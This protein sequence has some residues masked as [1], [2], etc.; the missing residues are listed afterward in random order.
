[1]TVADALLTRRAVKHYDP[2]FELPAEDVRALL[3][4]IALSPTAFNMQNRHVVVVRDPAVKRPLSD[5]AFGQAQVRDAS[6]VFVLTGDLSAHRRPERFLRNAPPQARAALEPMIEGFYGDADALLRDEAC[7]SVGLAAMSLM[8]RARE[9]GYDTCPM[10]GF[11]PVQVSEVLA[12]DAD[13]PPLMLVT[14]GRGTQAPHPRLGFLDLGESVSIDR[15]GHHT[16]R[17]EPVVEAEP[18]ACSA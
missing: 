13:H 1:M 6:A 7:R 4:A 2:E 15:F 16:L 18:V 11:D 12:L 8:L 10:S 17:G 14:V 3:S 9:L 5:A